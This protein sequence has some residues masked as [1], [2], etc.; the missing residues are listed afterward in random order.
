MLES[1][2]S[3]PSALRRTVARIWRRLRGEKRSPA[4]VAA[5][6][7]TGLFIGVLPLYGLHFVLCLL[8]C[9]PLGLDFVATY[10]V[11]NISNPF[12]APFLITLEVEVGALVTTGQHA[13]F[14][15][16]RAKQTGILGFAWQAGVGSVLVG[17]AFA[18][19]GGG[20]AYVVARGRQ[21][22]SGQEPSSSLDDSAD[23]QREAALLRT[24]ERYRRAPIGDRLYVAGKLRSDPV[25]RML[26]ALPGKLGRVLD[27]G[28]GRG[29]F[30]LL[31]VELGR[32]RELVGFD[33]DARKIGLFRDAAA[34][35][36][37]VE[38]RDL[39]EPP[40]LESDTVLLIDVLHYLPKNE[41][42]E[43]LRQVAAR[44]PQRGARILIR[45]LDAVPGARSALTRI[46][47]WLARMSG[48]NRG[49]AAHHY[50]PA[51]ELV[52]ELAQC[53]FACEVL[54]ASE[55]TPFGNVLIVA[56]R[57]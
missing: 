14:T 25:T 38:V 56:T 16:A 29:Q 52:R 34:G 53:G 40:D 47:E 27:A 20:A 26:V 49:R 8:V 18:A 45:E 54:G 41:Q 33:S 11:A 39:L 35:A 10:L 22:S 42:S 9:L 31:L 3:Q 37:R 7:A 15:L 5:A 43:L 48:Y 57:T 2:M 1:A 13:A 19:I 17:L 32:A 6:V 30:G 55:G 24:I 44:V 36:A 12:L 51:S 21:R 28:S 23:E 46:L 50:R 4:R